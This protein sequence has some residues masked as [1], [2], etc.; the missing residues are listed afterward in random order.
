MYQETLQH[1]QP[2]QSMPNQ[3]R[4]AVSFLCQIVTLSSTSQHSDQDLSAQVAL[5]HFELN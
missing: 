3:D 5:S 2:L 4:S 1:H